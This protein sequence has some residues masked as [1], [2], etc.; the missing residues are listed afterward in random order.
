MVEVFS[1]TLLFTYF[2]FCV[3]F[4]ALGHIPELI[5]TVKLKRPF[6]GYAIKNL[7]DFVIFV[8]FHS[9]TWLTY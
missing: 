3:C 9:Y 4:F 1:Y 8:F 5:Y 7:L 6:Y 2:S